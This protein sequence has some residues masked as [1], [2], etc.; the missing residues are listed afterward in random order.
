MNTRYKRS[1]SMSV[2]FTRDLNKV[3]DVDI[4]FTTADL[5][6]SFVE[7]NLLHDGET[8]DLNT[9]RLIIN[10]MKRNQV[11]TQSECEI[12][13]ATNGKIK[14]P[15]TTTMLSSPGRNYFEILLIKDGTQL[16]SLKIPYKVLKTINDDINEA[17]P[18]TNEFP[19]LIQL[20]EDVKELKNTTNAFL[21]EA[22]KQE[23]IRG[24]NENVR[25]SQESDRVKSMNS[26]KS[27]FDNKIIEVNTAKNN[28]VSDVTTA[29]DTMKQEVSAAK[30][31]MVSDVTSA[32]NDMISKVNA[33]ITDVENSKNTMVTKVDDKI[34]EIEDRFQTLEDERAVVET[35][36]GEYLTFDNTKESIIQDIEVRGNTIQNP[37]NL[38]DIKSV[39]IDNGDGT[40]K[41]SILS[42]NGLDKSNVNYKETRCDITLPRP[43]RSTL[44]KSI[45]DRLYYDK[46][47]KNWCIEQNV[48]DD[49]NVLGDG[50]SIIHQLPKSVDILLESYSERTDMWVESGEVN[51]TVKAT[52]SKSLA[53]T[54]QA[55]TNEINILNDKVADIEGLKES[56][57]FAYE[58]D[59]GYLVCK[60]T[61]NGV[62]KDLKIYGK[63]IKGLLEIGAK[64]SYTLN[65]TT[66]SKMFSLIETIPAN[67]DIYIRV[68]I[69]SKKAPLEGLR[70]NV[71]NEDGTVNYFDGF[72]GVYEQSL[73]IK[74]V[75]PIKKIGFYLSSN[76]FTNDATA[77]ITFE[78]SQVTLVDIGTNYIEGIASV[79]NGNEIEV[80]SM[81][82]NL[83]NKDNLL[84]EGTTVKPIVKNNGFEVDYS[85]VISIPYY[86]V[87]CVSDSFL[88]L[89]TIKKGSGDILVR[90]YKSLSDLKISSNFTF[91]KG[92]TTVGN[93]KGVNVPN[94]TKLIAFHRG[95]SSTG[96]VEIDNIMIT[97]GNASVFAEHKQDKKPILYKDGDVWK[98]VT[99]LRGIDL[100][101]CDTIEKHSDGKYYLHIRTGKGVLNGQENWLTANPLSNTKMYYFDYSEVKVNGLIISDKLIYVLP[102]NLVSNDS[103]GISIS[104]SSNRILI[105]CLNSKL[106]TQDVNGFKKWLQS[107]AITI[108][109]QLAQEKVYEVSPLDLEA[110]ENETMI[111]FGSGVIAPKAEWKITSNAANVIKNQGKRLT[112][113][114][115]DFYKYTVAQNRMMLASRYSADRV[116]FKID[117]TMRSVMAVKQDL[118]YDLFNLLKANIIVGIENYDRIDME[119]KMDFYV[120]SGVIDW[121][122]WD[123]LYALIELQHNPPTEMT[124]IDP[125]V[126]NTPEELPQI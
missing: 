27:T 52:I 47:S 42:S 116:D 3:P 65:T 36:T 58:T 33:K 89:D 28:M 67:T 22:Q 10:I 61:K 63:T 54:V 15:F 99:E 100:S 23:D 106:E 75:K 62:V 87:D 64:S 88:Y 119:Q 45:K 39:G 86:E 91:S 46:K 124:P 44:D 35:K 92:I 50:V 19:I 73:K 68:N 101:A 18:N 4:V 105:R 79:G 93:L 90:G 121:D 9:Y 43:L 66:R 21:L 53:S 102:N 107:N 81:N 37:S 104:G 97:R 122:M 76:E 14:I 78:K 84:Y 94:G 115:N 12:V 11:V 85:G 111:S 26:M 96:L 7:V 109:Y 113:L 40:Y 56:Q 55:N 95:S 38:S 114:E 123:E 17:I 24:K 2:D 60:D 80:L 72:K 34:N 25:V 108:I 5:N 70:I 8:V 20:I 71:L 120:N 1:Y 125:G 110:F 77:N 117:N 6:T 29:K 98:P 74:H 82:E 16:P 41:M 31:T 59:K 48:D 49:S 57:D 83:I 112:R 126:N 69:T 118:D 13:D 30:N 32:K 51:A 103:E